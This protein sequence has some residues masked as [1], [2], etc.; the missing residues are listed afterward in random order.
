L[1]AG[2][3]AEHHAP[4]WLRSP[5]NWL[6][7]K[8]PADE[9]LLMALR[10]AMTVTLVHPSSMSPEEARRDW[11]AYL[12]NRLK[13]RVGAFLFYLLVLAPSILISV[14]PGPNL[15]GFWVT[16]RLVAHALTLIGIV[17]MLKGRAV[18]T[19]QSSEFL[20]GPVI[21]DR[22]RTQ[23]VQ[24]HFN[25]IGLKGRLKRERVLARLRNRRGRP[26]QQHPDE[27]SRH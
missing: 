19:A 11:D 3:K 12:E 2:R 6:K 4:L 9:R 5:I 8:L 10:R 16:F 1:Q 27:G 22:R 23:V 14:L 17:R 21:T 24:E 26:D 25:L 18:V 15:L 20:D 13:F 7:S